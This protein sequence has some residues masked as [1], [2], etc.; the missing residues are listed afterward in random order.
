MENNLCE[1]GTQKVWKR[2]KPKEKW[3]KNECK[4]L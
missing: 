2:A 1:R 4:Q 3:F